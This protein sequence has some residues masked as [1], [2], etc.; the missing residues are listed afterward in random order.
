MAEIIAHD[1]H[2]AQGGTPILKGASIALKSGELVALIGPNGAGK[3]TLLRAIMALQTITQGSI[4]WDG[5]DPR[6]LSVTQR[7]RKLA[8]LPQVRPLAWP[9]KVE[10]V[11]AL[12]RFA[13]G[14]PFQ[15]PTQS[16]GEAINKAIEACDLASLCARDTT[17]LSGGELARTHIA[18]VLAA[19]TPLLIADEPSAALDPRHAYETMSILKDYCAKGGGALVTLHDLSLAARFAD[20]IVL[21]HDGQ[22]LADGSPAAV[23]TPDLMAQAFGVRARLVD[24]GVIVDGV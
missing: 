19:Q 7:A 14:V 2:L 8:Y 13:Y 6:Q 16:D 17:T 12:G 5:S 18:R 21:L 20:R 15:K 11:V 10:D 9:L 23:L 1:I 4:S 24:G 3:S 22:V